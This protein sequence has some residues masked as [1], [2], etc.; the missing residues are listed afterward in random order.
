MP[1]LAGLLVPRSRSA[2]TAR[3][4]AATSSGDG[5]AV[6]HD[7][8]HTARRQH[9]VDRSPMTAAARTPGCASSISSIRPGVIF[10]PS[11]C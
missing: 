4:S 5:G 2:Q 11:R 10:F 7:V 9:L 6:R 8:G 1:E 3:S